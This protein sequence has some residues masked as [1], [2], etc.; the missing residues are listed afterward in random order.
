MRWQRDQNMLHLF[1]YIV[2]LSLPSVKTTSLDRWTLFSHLVLLVTKW[3]SA[4]Q[5]KGACKFLVISWPWEVY[6]LGFLILKVLTHLKIYSENFE[7]KKNS[8]QRTKLTKTN[9]LIGMID[10]I[11]IKKRNSTGADPGSFLGGGALVSCSTSTPINHI[12]FFSQNTSCIRKPQVIPAPSPWIRPCSNSK[13]NK[14]LHRLYQFIQAML[15]RNYWRMYSRM[16]RTEQFK[17]Q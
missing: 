2:A 10:G 7:K 11:N 16:S 1:S 6:T 13:Y 8:E 4:F 9:V 17:E 12:V 15:S 14:P 5:V 3:T